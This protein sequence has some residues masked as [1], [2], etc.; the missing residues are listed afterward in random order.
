MLTLSVALLAFVFT[1]AQAEQIKSIHLHKSSTLQTVTIAM[2]KPL[3]YEV[4][5]LE[6]PPRLVLNFS[7]S[8]LRRGVQPL[9]DDSSGVKSVFPL[10]SADG[11][12]LEISMDR[13]LSYKVEEK[14]K[15]LELHF[16]APESGESTEKA[17]AEVQDI[18]VR[19][20]GEVTEL[21]LRGRNM[22]ANRNIFHDRRW[23]VSYS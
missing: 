7:G 11:V 19:D 9:R 4:Y 14:G 8:T 15:E 17:K 22:D 16:Q 10:V 18:E 12:R 6:S 2:D 3:M 1:D 5:N 23:P 13:I 21:R 20:K